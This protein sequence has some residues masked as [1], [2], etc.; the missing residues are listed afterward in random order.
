MVAGLPGKMSSVVAEYIERSPDLLLA[1]QNLSETEEIIQIGER[2]V[3]INP[4]AKHKEII[5]A[6]GPDII[7]DFTMP[8]A[9]IRNAELYCMCKTPF[10][11]GTTGGDPKLLNE[12]VEA[13]WI[14]AVI[15]PNMLKQIVMLMDMMGYAAKNFP[16]AFKGY[17]LEIIESHQEGKKDT[18]GTAKA[19]IK[20]FNALG[21]PFEVNQIVMIRDPGVQEK[22]LKVPNWALTGHGWHTYTLRNDEG[23]V[24][25]QFT[26]NVN[27]RDGYAQGAL[28]AI[29]FLAKQEEGIGRVFSM[30]DVLR[31]N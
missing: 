6:V 29:R 1:S 14:P 12:T 23:G 9:V 18:S 24:L 17:T 30:I 19:M 26:H 10:V 15:A 21:I 2:S 25:F 31:G 16:N 5:K 27:G 4:L 11:M 7:V 13:S 8:D 20:H 22:L 28:D 3:R